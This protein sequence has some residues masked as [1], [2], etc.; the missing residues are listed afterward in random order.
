[1]HAHR[2]PGAGRLV[3][4]LT[5][6][7]AAGAVLPS[8]GASVAMGRE[9]VAHAAATIDGTATSHLHLVTA[10]GSRLTEEGTV[11]GA[12]VGSIRAELKTGAI[13]TASFTI[14]TH[15]GSIT[16]HGQAN[17]HGSGRY[18]SFRGSFLATNGSGRYAHVSG[19][20]GLYGVFDRRTYSV[21]IQTTGMFTY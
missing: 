10:E 11:A 1:M 16:G 3:T 7:I 6:F 14:H 17:P 2:R 12:L 19:H 18:Q 20:A 5:V 4:A 21:V 8:A 9:Q 15:D 13:F